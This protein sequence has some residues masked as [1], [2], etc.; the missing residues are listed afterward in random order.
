M[1]DVSG[2]SSFDWALHLLTVIL[3]DSVI[4]GLSLSLSV[5]Q[6]SEGFFCVS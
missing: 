1:F 3:H 4:H 5:S 2:L 6:E